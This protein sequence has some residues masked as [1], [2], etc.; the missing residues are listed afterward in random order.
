VDAPEEPD[1]CESGTSP[2]T[3]GSVRR[4]GFSGSGGTVGR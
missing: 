3:E 4:A 1:A 2:D